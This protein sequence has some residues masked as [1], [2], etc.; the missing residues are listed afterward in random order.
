MIIRFVS[1]IFT[2]EEEEEEE[3]GE[4]GEDDFSYSLEFASTDESILGNFS[5]FLL[6]LDIL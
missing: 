3:E 6:A 1:T 5:L 4:E 2:E